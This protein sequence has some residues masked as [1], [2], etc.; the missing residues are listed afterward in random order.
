MP[1][2]SRGPSALS[3]SLARFFAFAQAAREPADPPAGWASTLRH[4]HQDGGA[5][6]RPGSRRRTPRFLAVHP[7][8]Q[9]SKGCPQ[10]KGYVLRLPARHAKLLRQAS[11][12]ARVTSITRKTT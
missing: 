8:G 4:I 5:E 3:F 10:M 1:S 9:M 11:G 6:E 7:T 2:R 12:D